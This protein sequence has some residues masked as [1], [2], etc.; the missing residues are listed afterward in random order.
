[1]G[2]GVEAAGWWPGA[3]EGL[4]WSAGW[5]RMLADNEEL[6]GRGGKSFVCGESGGS[7]SIRTLLQPD[8]DIT[9]TGGSESV[10]DAALARAHAEKVQQWTGRVQRDWAAANR[11]LNVIAV[12]VALAVTAAGWLLADPDDW[13]DLLWLVAL[14]VLTGWVVRRTIAYVLRRL[15]LRVV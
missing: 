8:G 12:A 4:G 14:P 7:R 15:V 6:F 9:T 10:S 13:R 5:R 11:L 2:V 1:M 3:E